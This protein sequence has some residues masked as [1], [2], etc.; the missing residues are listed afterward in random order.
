MR[1]TV[2]QW[3][4]HRDGLSLSLSQKEEKLVLPSEIM[5]LRDLECYV[6]I[7]NYDISQTTLTYRA[8]HESE[9]PLLLREELIL[10]SVGKPVRETLTG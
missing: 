4:S 2:W 6:K 1:P 10:T 3:Q 9:E 8:F 5:N 7:P